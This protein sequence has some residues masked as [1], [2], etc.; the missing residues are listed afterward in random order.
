MKTV[1]LQGWVRGT[2]DNSLES[3]SIPASQSA[4]LTTWKSLRTATL[5]MHGL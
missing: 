2:D 5:P 4:T 1:R 3:M